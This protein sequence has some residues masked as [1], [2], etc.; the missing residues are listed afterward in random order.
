[1]KQTKSRIIRS[2]TTKGQMHALVFVLC[3]VLAGIAHSGQSDAYWPQ[4]HGP[5]RDNISAEKGLPKQWPRGGP[6]LL[7]TAQGLGH[8]YSS[9]SIADGMIYTASSLG[10]HTVVIALNLEGEVLWQVKNGAA[11]TGP[12]PGSRGTPTIDGRRLYHQSPLGNLICLDAKTGDTIWQFNIIEKVRS[13][14]PRWALAESLLVDGNHLISCPGGPQAHMVALNKENGSLIW[15][16]PSTGELA[17]YASPILLEH[18]GLRMI[19]TLTAKSFIGINADT[20]D[21]LWRVRHESPYDENIMTPIFHDGCVFIS[22]PLAGSVKW[23]VNVHN[24]KVSLEEL[25]RT[26]EL[27]NHHGGVILVNGNLYGSSTARNKN[28]FVCLDWKSGRRRYRGKCVGK[29]S[30]TYA[31]GMLYALSIDGNVGLVQPTS[32]GHR[33]VSHF[34]IPHGGKGK[35]WAHPVVCGGR[36]YIRHGAFL[37][38]YD[39]RQRQGS[40]SPEGM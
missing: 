30:L 26:R 4:F 32:T 17:G 23:K 40:V 25:W 22:T 2:E 35:S 20:G 9:I 1:M 14:V 39:L 6:A 29:A 24:G 33:L 8:G 10:G 12:Y 3:L 19:T 28:L 38:A 13:R 27:D 37:Y 5:N 31:D 7:W 11:W 34:R 36:L 18:A 16:S 15:K 21:L